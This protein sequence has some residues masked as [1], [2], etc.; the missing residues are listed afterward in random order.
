MEFACYATVFPKNIMNKY[1][2][3]SSKFS[4]YSTG[5][6][7]ASR[8]MWTENVQCPPPPPPPPETG[9]TVIVTSYTVVYTRLLLELSSKRPA[10]FPV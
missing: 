4:L 10:P 8:H 9:Q 7:L 5:K 6:S 3:D 1:D 2:E